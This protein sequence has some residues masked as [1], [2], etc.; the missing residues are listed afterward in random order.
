MESE[1]KFLDNIEY[2]L[3]IKLLTSLE[4]ETYNYT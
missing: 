3:S 4:T 1:S 2:T